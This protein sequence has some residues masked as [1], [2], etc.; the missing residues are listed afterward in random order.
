MRILIVDVYGKIRSVGKI[1]SLQYEYLKS[2]GHQ[3]R[4]VYRG[5]RE[6]VI[7]NPDYIRV[8]NKVEFYLSKLITMLTGLEGHVH[9][10]ATR[11]LKKLTKTFNP[12]IVQLNNLHGYFINNSKY[13]AFLRDRN[14]P[15]VYT[16]IDEYP[17]MGK[18]P[19]SKEC[20][21]F[22]VG[23]SSPCP[24]KRT[25]P[26][27]LIFDNARFIW[28]GKQKAYQGYDNIVFT[29]PRWVVERAKLSA[30]LKGK[31]IV[32]LDEPIHFKSCFYPRNTRILKEKLGI[33]E[34]NKVIVTVT[35][36]SAPSKGGI[37]FYE[38]ARLLKQRKDISFVY[39]GL[40]TEEPFSLDNL[41]P[42]RYVNSQ[43][44]LADYY[45]LG[46]VFVS[47]SL[48]DTQPNACLEALG[49]G[50]PLIAFAA[51]GLP[52]IAPGNLE[53]LVEPQN[54]AKL[55]EAFAK[56]EKKTEELTK[57]CREYALGRYSSDIV[58]SKL[59]EIYKGLVNE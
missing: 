54:I 1:T 52:Y 50:T 45:S 13:I 16:M 39:V 35:R 44:E 34:G 46:D 11:R 43:D 41:I 24:Q 7:D 6:P 36:M 17:Y 27:S 40:D 55:A 33:P 56:V 4:V 21:K 25:Y 22:T 10:I 57:Q 31:N 18:C 15:A 20:N 42:I 23:C 5:Y 37:Y 49:C 9:P 3:V 53:L 19:Y 58:M 38:A 59:V 29:G 30:L 48:A 12:D 32:E 47:C 14:C 51:M 28:E 2:H 8:A 26:K